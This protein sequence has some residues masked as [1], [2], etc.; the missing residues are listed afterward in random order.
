MMKR[1]VF[2]PELDFQKYSEIEPFVMYV[3]EFQ[4]ELSQDEL[5]DIWQGVMPDIAMI[6]ELDSDEFTHEVG[7][8]EFFG[9]RPL[10]RANTEQVRWMV[11]KVKKRA[12]AN[13]YATTIEN[14]QDEVTLDN[15]RKQLEQNEFANPLGYDYNYNWPYDYFSLVEL[16][17]IDVENSFT[18]KPT[19]PERDLGGTVNV[20]DPAQENEIRNVTADTSNNYTGAGSPGTV[21][22]A[23]NASTFRGGDE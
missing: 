11:F 23:V 21:G 4:H 22:G 1:Y 15:P 5:K 12:H 6:P 17:Q 8:N 16:A 2:P 14:Y 7:E 10:P 9:G 13:W 19:L 3:M 18:K 20:T